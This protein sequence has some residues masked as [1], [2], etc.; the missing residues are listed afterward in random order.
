MSNAVC[1]KCYRS[2]FA[3]SNLHTPENVVC[4]S[5]IGKN[6]TTC[7]CVVCDMECLA[8]RQNLVTSFYM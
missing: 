2:F 5:I 4:T 1:I 8:H 3:K 6:T 7:G